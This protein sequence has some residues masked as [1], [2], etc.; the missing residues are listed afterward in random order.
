MGI[1]R[2]CCNKK[3]FGGNKVMNPFV[4]FSKEMESVLPKEPISVLQ[5]SNLNPRLIKPVVKTA[6]KKKRIIYSS[7]E[8]VPEEGQFDAI[9]KKSK[10]ENVVKPESKPSIKNNNTSLQSQICK[11]EKK[12]NSTTPLKLEKEISKDKTLGTSK[13]SVLDKTQFT[14]KCVLP[15]ESVLNETSFDVFEHD[16]SSPSHIASKYPSISKFNSNIL[17][18]KPS[19]PQKQNLKKTTSISKQKTTIIKEEDF[20]EDWEV[21]KNEIIPCEKKTRSYLDQKPLLD[22]SQGPKLVMDKKMEDYFK[23]LESQNKR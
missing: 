2:F 18:T 11:G 14:R 1:A 8:F 12:L 17:Q 3:L 20:S 22:E 4:Q 23:F 6:P 15:K 16:K 9:E 13:E 10:S 21:K 5:K 19:L 7:Q